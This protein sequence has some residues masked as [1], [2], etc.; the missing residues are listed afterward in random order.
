MGV[1][2]ERGGRQR[3]VEAALGGRSRKAVLE[4]RVGRAPEAMVGAAHFIA[5]SQSAVD[6]NVTR[7]IMR[8]TGRTPHDA[9]RNGRDDD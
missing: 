6:V 7:A 3:C 8:R 2:L 5:L 4:V 1:A 9:L